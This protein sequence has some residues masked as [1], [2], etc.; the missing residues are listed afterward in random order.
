M[1]DDQ[2]DIVISGGTKFGNGWFK[3]VL[4]RKTVVLAITTIAALLGSG[5]L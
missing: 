4:G 3:V 2:E 5:S 1:K